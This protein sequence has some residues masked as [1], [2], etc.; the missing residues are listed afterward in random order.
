M[1]TGNSC[2]DTVMKPFTYRCVGASLKSFSNTAHLCEQ[3]FAAQAPG[4]RVGNTAPMADYKL[5]ATIEQN[6]PTADP[7]LVSL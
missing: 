2:G 5:L 6:T 4:R 3:G 1:I 7:K